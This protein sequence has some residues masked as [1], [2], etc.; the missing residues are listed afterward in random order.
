MR[1]LAIERLRSKPFTHDLVA[2]ARREL[3]GWSS[4]L[5]WGAS[6]REPVRRTS[7]I[8][9][10]LPGASRRENPVTTRWHSRG[11]W[12]EPVLASVEPDEFGGELCSRMGNR[13]ARDSKW[14]RSVAYEAFRAPKTMTGGDCSPPVVVYCWTIL[15][16]SEPSASSGS[17]TSACAADRSTRHGPPSDPRRSSRPK[18]DGALPQP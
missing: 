7:Y 2:G 1:L 9:G 3:Q 17:R 16:P 14:S 11:S 6:A 18:S 12:F 13:G 15:S 5:C 8:G 4:R 10:A